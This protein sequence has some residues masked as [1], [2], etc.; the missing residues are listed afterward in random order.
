MVESIAILVGALFAVFFLFVFW[1]FIF[2]LL[3]DPCPHCRHWISRQATAC[4]HCG[5]DVTPRKSQF[6]LFLESQGTVSRKT[7]A[8]LA[9]TFVAGT[10]LMLAIAV[11]R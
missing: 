6:D 11:F 9:G 8:W 7:V 3:L 10:L 4:G 1:Q 5:R 2:G